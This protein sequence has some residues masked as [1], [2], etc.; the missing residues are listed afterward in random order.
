MRNALGSLE[1][2]GIIEIVKEKGMFG[3]IFRISKFGY[4][5]SP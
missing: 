1:A 3:R 2:Q 4:E 5:V